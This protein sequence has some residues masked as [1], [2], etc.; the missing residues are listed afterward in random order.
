[1]QVKDVI[2]RVRNIAGDASALQ[3]TDV[4]IV[5]W[6]N[7]GMGE[8]AVI[9]NLLQ[10]SGSQN[11]IPTQAEYTL[12]VDMLKIHSIYF[13]STKLRVLTLQEFEQQYQGAGT[14][15]ISD[16]SIPTCA[17]IWAAKLT[18]YP[19]PVGIK[20]LQIN[21]VRTPAVASAGSP[22]ALSTEL[23]LPVSYHRRIV[24]YCLAQV[25]QQDED[26][27]RYSTKMQEFKTGVQEIKDE[28]ETQDD[29]YP[30]FS[31]SDRDTGDGIYG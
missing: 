26:F 11:T 19:A 12:P 1:M 16:P 9:N 24:D 15:N 18:L 13:D 4:Q 2:N 20:S 17:Y 8:C 21:F 31:I 22:A 14:N 25:A 27:N 10:K 7:D 6:I 30:S 28:S 5:D 23:D 3:F 29:L